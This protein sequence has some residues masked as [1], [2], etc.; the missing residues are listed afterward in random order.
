MFIV[1]LLFSLACRCF[2]SIG[3]S[4]SAN[5][6]RLFL[7]PPA[8]V[9]QEIGEVVDVAVN[10]SDVENLHSCGLTI[11]Y[12]TSLLNIIQVV[13]GDFFPQQAAFEYEKNESYGF[14]TV[15]ISL[16]ESVPSLSGN[17]T[18]AQLTFEVTQAPTICTAI[19]L[20]LDQ[21]RLYNPSLEPIDC[22]FVGAVYFWRSMQPDP[23]VEGRSLDLYTQRGGEGRGESGGEFMS[24]EMV[25]LISRVMYT[26]YPEQQKLVAFQVL[27][28]FNETVLIRVAITDN[29]GLAM[30]SF[31]I[32]SILGSNGSWRVF[33]VVEIAEEIVWDT[34]SFQV[35]RV[36]P[37]G[38]YTFPIKGYRAE[39]PLTTYPALVAILTA[40]FTIVRRKT[41]KGFG[42]RTRDMSFILIL[43]LLLVRFNVLFGTSE[44]T[45]ILITDFYSC[46][47][48]GNLQDYFPVKTTAYFNISV[49]NLTQDPKNISLSVS[50]VDELSVPI[51]FDQLNTTIPPDVSMHYVMSIFIPKWAH[52]GVATA[53]AAVLIEG[54]VIDGESTEFYIGPE[55]LTPPVIHLLCPENVTYGTESVPLVFAVN[56]RTFWMG[57]NLNNLGNVSIAG[58]T[59]LTDLTNGLYSTIVYANDT[60]GNVGS[61]EEVYFTIL[62]VH[63]VAV[64]DVNC[65]S[66]EVYAGQIV[67]VTVFV[68]NQGTVT[69]TFNVTTYANTTAIETLNVTNLSPSNQA[70]LV[71]TWNTTGVPKGNYTIRAYI[72]P[73]PSETDI[74]DN[75]YIDDI[76]NIMQPPDIAVTNVTASKTSVGQGFSML[77]DVT[78]RNQG[79]YTENFNV[80]TYAN[81]TIISTL[82]D[83]TLTSG[84]STTI[85]FMWNTTGFAKGNCTITAYATALLYEIDTTDN[86]L[87]DGWVVVTILG[88]TNG[89]GWVEMM[90]FWVVSQAYGSHLGDPNWNSNADIYSW[91]DGDDYVEMMDFWVVNQHYGEHY[92]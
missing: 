1:L 74:T 20:K 55:D 4:S 2:T 68:Q 28:P 42:R 34:L 79:D 52:V 3:Q 63:D 67:N 90:D 75:T 66:A 86:T 56:E 39:K 61:S 8:Y 19:V 69:E 43:L 16:P 30:V 53:Y 50:V 76:V 9:V 71:F 84:N 65:S 11:T 49:R 35:Y 73:V 83:I 24:G 15:N 72:T 14:V 46:D 10:T 17:G 5:C 13:Q 6:A 47:R 62:I 37:V 41:H 23:P 91:P 12:N 58:N 27:N 57:Y 29:D 59:T 78:V 80:T 87:V 85:T 82:T 18:L 45:D 81:E 89:D 88:D 22:K 40:G 36:I 60:S 77:I 92:P 26:N 48:L 64:I 31:R 51:G 54:S 33:S 44:G 70:I 25:Y 7:F 21:I 32:P 38:G